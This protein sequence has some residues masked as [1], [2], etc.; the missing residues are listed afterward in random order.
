MSFHPITPT[1]S[2]RQRLPL[3]RDAMPS[4][5]TRTENVRMNDSALN[6]TDDA[7]ASAATSHRF[8]G[9]PATNAVLLL[10]PST[11]ANRHTAVAITQPAAVSIG[12][13]RGS[14]N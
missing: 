4:V 2:L 7:P 3:V 9:V 12:G 6:I 5:S 8:T 14:W 13:S 11:T 1:R 10:K